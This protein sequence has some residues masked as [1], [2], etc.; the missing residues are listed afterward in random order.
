[1]NLIPK[2]FVALLLCLCLLFQGGAFALDEEPKLYEEG[3]SEA[4]LLLGDGEPGAFDLISQGGGNTGG[5]G[6]DGD[7]PP[8]F[9]AGRVLIK[10][11]PDYVQAYGD[12]PGELYGGL[13]IEE[14]E[15][16]MTLD[17]GSEDGGDYGAQS[18]SGNAEIILLKLSDASEEATLQAIEY[19]NT[20]PNIE[21]AEPDYIRTANL[22]DPFITNP[23]FYNMDLIGATSLWDEGGYFGNGI[24][25]AVLDTGIDHTHSDLAGRVTSGWNFVAGN[26][27]AMDDNWHGTHVA[28]IIGAIGNN[29]IGGAGVAYNVTL[30]PLKVLDANGRGN[31]SYMIAAINYA[32]SRNVRISNHSYG[33]TGYSKA[34]EEAIRDSNQLVVAAAGNE[35]LNNEQVPHYPSGY[36]LPNVISVAATGMS[37]GTEI[38]ADFSNYGVNSVHI[39]APGAN[40]V[41]TAASVEIKDGYIIASGTSQ[42]TPHVAGAAAVL[43][44]REPSLSAAALRARLLDYADELPALSGKVSGAKRLNVY[45]SVKKSVSTPA[46]SV[47]LD[48]TALSLKR[49]EAASLTAT[50]LPANASNKSITWRSSNTG[51]AAVSD[52]GLVTAVGNGSA[53]ITAQLAYDSGVYAQCSVT[54]SGTAAEIVF[55]DPYFKALVVEALKQSGNAKYENY[56]QDSVIYPGDA[57]ALTAL[58]LSAAG[59]RDLGGIEHFSNLWY[60]NCSGN[61]IEQLDVSALTALEELNCA[62]NRIRALDL[63]ANANMRA[64]DCQ[65]NR[66]HTLDFAAASPWSE[67]YCNDNLLNITGE[68]STKLNSVRSKTGASRFSSANQ[69]SAAGIEI[70]PGVL[71]LD[72]GGTTSFRALFGPGGESPV[73]WSVGNASVASIAPDGTLT[74]LARGTTTVRVTLAADLSV[75]AEATLLVKNPAQDGDGSAENPY[76]IRTADDLRALSVYTNEMA[77]A[78]RAQYLSA[79]YLLDPGSGAIDMTGVLFEPIGHILEGREEESFSG[80][81]DGNGKEIRNLTIYQN[82]FETESVGMFT[83]ISGE[84]KNLSLQNIEYAV[85][86][87]GPNYM[88]GV[89]A[90]AGLI[91]GG[92]VSNVSA[93]GEINCAY[94]DIQ[95]A[96]GLAGGVVSGSVI[97]S[98]R[99]DVNVIAQSMA[100]GLAGLISSG[101]QVSDCRAEGDVSASNYGEASAL[102]GFVGQILSGSTVKNSSAGGKATG[103]SAVG[104]F[105]GHCEGTVTNSFSTGGAQGT[106]YV[107][108]FAGMAYGGNITN[109]YAHGNA[110]GADS[111]GGFVGVTLSTATVIQ[112][113]YAA[114]AVSGGNGVGGFVGDNYEGSISYCYATGNVQGDIYVG[115]FAGY[116]ATTLPMTYRFS[117]QTVTALSE[118]PN[119]Y[120][121]AA[122]Q[123][124]LTSSSFLNSV[125]GA[126]FETSVA[127]ANG[128]HAKLYKQNTTTLLPDQRSRAITGSSPVT[129]S[130][131]VLAYN[132][133][134]QV[135]I[136]LYAAGT[137][138]LIAG[139]SLSLPAGTGQR[140]ALFALE[141]VPGG[142]TYD[143]VIRKDCHLDYKLTGIA[144]G[145]EDIDLSANGNAQI[146]SIRLPCGRL[147]GNNVIDSR[148]LNELIVPRNYGKTVGG[149]NVNSKADLNGD[150]VIDSRDLNIIILPANYGKTSPVVAYSE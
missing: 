56:T 54:V 10:T 1:M 66:L 48:A 52:A 128:W 77:P 100:G 39:A 32:K 67:F 142:A 123:A 17:G 122:T 33:G 117:G 14:A 85:N 47:S 41:S 120:G 112:R 115:G 129:I 135:S 37:G 149:S 96:G 31:T 140:T 68:L 132:P 81:F 80:V 102:G 8:E 34:F 138:T 111:V 106:D 27:N 6:D 3:Q 64:L 18:S 114:G 95:G 19:L 113:C 2:K 58:D 21:Y 9:D 91:I 43:L 98:C 87:Y 26:S 125:L 126:Q 59:I 88:G 13:E 55:A 108:G 53:V 71:Q 7:E 4:A 36:N 63:S 139:M 65:F 101:S 62:G 69:E 49:G 103:G 28:G 16:L 44:S 51:V 97:S 70:A 89:G 30:M 99:A 143:L 24:T 29:G 20:L 145:E 133:N 23:D 38:L 107:G 147:L 15:T 130:G 84:V 5:N 134:S 46:T 94:G 74:A 105:A 83:A 61:Q 11:N 22:N 146:S 118:S 104:G 45:N 93:S 148:D 127:A 109:C 78:V 92:T 60:L 79:N 136:S 131:R 150:G 12:D 121:A 119:S 90:L 76:K 57:G 35:G 124:N 73:L 116:S 110:Q 137:E 75:L 144:V 72:I 141:N 40:I 50:A 82:K 86:F 25:V 42:A